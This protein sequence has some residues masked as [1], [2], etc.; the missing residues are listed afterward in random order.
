MSVGEKHLKFNGAGGILLNIFYIFWFYMFFN[1]FVFGEF[2]NMVWASFENEFNFMFIFFFLFISVAAFALVPRMVKSIYYLFTQKPIAKLNFHGIEFIYPLKGKIEW[3]NVEHVALSGAPPFYTSLVI[4]TKAPT[5]LAKKF[6]R[7]NFLQGGGLDIF[8]KKPE[9][10]IRILLF[11][12]GARKSDII[13][14]FE[15]YSK[16]VG[17]FKFL[18]L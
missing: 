13:S 14:A 3:E 4:T 1:L 18:D 16:L 8:S 5:K 12:F 15:E 10:K 9:T 11:D 17:T 2:G 6:K 7:R